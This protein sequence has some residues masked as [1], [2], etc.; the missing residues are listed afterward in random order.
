MSKVG[1]VGLGVMGNGM[2]QNLIKSGQDVMV[3]DVRP[4]ACDAA[5]GLGAERAGSL[6]DMAGCDPVL[7]MVNT[8]DQASSVI[9]ALSKAV[10]S[11]KGLTVAIMSTIE[12][13]ELRKLAGQ[14]KAKGIDV[15]DAPVSGGPVLANAGQLSIMAG[16]TESQVDKVRPALE[17]MSKAVFHVG[18]AGQGLAM[19]LVNN[20]ITI[21]NMTLVPAALKVGLE[22]GLNL[23]KMVE[24]IKAS[25]GNNFVIE[26][27]EMALLVMDIMIGNEASKQNQLKINEKDIRAFISLAKEMGID[28]GAGA[29]VLSMVLSDDQADKALLDKFKAAMA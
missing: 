18:D 24:V 17:P 14:Y 2:A 26:N 23:K 13:Q 22:A 12:P 29:G 5:V 9:S 15:I 28:S 1:F 7:V 19:K 10:D 21:A 3:Y 27:W 16:G 20:V 11:A 6:E 4:E 8:A 25:A